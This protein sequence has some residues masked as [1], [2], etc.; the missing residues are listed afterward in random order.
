MWLSTRLTLIIDTYMSKD[1][2]KIIDLI[3]IKSVWYF[4][5]YIIRKR[6]CRPIKKKHTVVFLLF[7]YVN[8]SK[9]LLCKVC[10][11]Y[12][13]YYYLR[14]GRFVVVC[15]SVCLFVCLLFVQLCAKTSEGI[16]MKVSSNIG[17]GPMNK[18]KCW[19]RSGSPCGYRDCFPESSLSGDT[20]TGI[21]RL[22]CTTPCTAASRSAVGWYHIPYLP[23]VTTPENNIR[24]RHS[25][26]DVITSP[27]HDRERDWYRDTGKTC[28][29][30]GMHCSSASSYMIRYHT[31]SLYCA[32]KLANSNFHL[33]H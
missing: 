20:E 7:I 15:V 22:R 29:G 32:E 12:H 3:S 11:S 18:L 8:L 5:V 28:L 16:C 26:Y 30:G 24:H 10:I 6:Q 31:K 19:W 9:M 4:N 23:I 27:A 14:Q 25:N 1:L 17:N 2:W 13:E 33:L 21:N